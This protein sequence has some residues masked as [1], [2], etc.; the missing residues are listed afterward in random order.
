MGTSLVVQMVKNW[1]AIQETHV[2]SL[3]WEKPSLL[4]EGKDTPLWCSC[5]EN[6]KDRGAWWG[7]VHGVTKSQTRLSHQTQHM[8]SCIYSFVPATQK[9]NKKGLPS[10][11]GPTEKGTWRRFRT[12]DNKVSSFGKCNLSCLGR[13]KNITAQVI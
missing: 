9:Q 11:L 8:L 12:T 1:P 5:L 2:Q 13:A 7:T 4:Q 3:G 10:Q 6:S